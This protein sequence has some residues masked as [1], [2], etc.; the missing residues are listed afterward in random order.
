MKHATNKLILAIKPQFYYFPSSSTILLFS[1]LILEFPPSQFD[2]FPCQLYLFSS[3]ST[4]FLFALLNLAFPPPPQFLYFPPSI[5]ISRLLHN[6][7]I[8]PPPPPPS[9]LNYIFFHPQIHRPHIDPAS[10]LDSF[11]FFNTASWIVK[12]YTTTTIFL[13]FLLFTKLTFFDYFN[14]ISNPNGGPINSH[15]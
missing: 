12:L 5:L 14:R 10:T 2:Y 15:H 13:L 1:V 11:P 6:F 3:S 8:F 4:I 9:H 7:I